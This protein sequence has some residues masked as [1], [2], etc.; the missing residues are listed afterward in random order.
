[1]D[2]KYILNE[3]RLSHDNNPEQHIANAL[4]AVLAR[5]ESDPRVHNVNGCYFCSAKNKILTIALQ[6]VREEKQMHEDHVE[7]YKAALEKALH[8]I[9]KKKFYRKID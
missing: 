1:M 6:I 7:E 5:R 9:F 2:D 4:G 8:E 3:L